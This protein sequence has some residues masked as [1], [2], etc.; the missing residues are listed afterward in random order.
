MK[1]RGSLEVRTVGK[2]P[3]REEP[4]NRIFPLSGPAA[5]TLQITA[6]TTYVTQR[7]LCALNPTPR[8]VDG[9]LAGLLGPP[10]IVPTMA[11]EMLKPRTAGCL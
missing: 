6:R 5:L 11:Q 3:R 7:A 4:L 1:E 9:P 2:M 10:A 8:G